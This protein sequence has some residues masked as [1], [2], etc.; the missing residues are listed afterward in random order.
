MKQKDKKDEDGVIGVIHF[1]D[2]QNDQSG[3][4]R[5]VLDGDILRVFSSVD[6]GFN[7][8]TM[9]GEII[10]VVQHAIIKDFSDDN[11]QGRGNDPIVLN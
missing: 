3:Y 11:E 6:D 4:M 1:E 2:V 10:A 9:M 5:F 8:D 7:V